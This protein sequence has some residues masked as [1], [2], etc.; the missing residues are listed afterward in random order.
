MPDG[1]ICLYDDERRVAAFAPVPIADVRGA[2]DAAQQ[3]T[4]DAAGAVLAASTAA[5]CAAVQ[6]GGAGGGVPAAGLSADGARRAPEVKRANVPLGW[7]APAFDVLQLEDYDW[8]IAGRS[9][10]AARRR[11]AMA[12]RLGYPARA[13]HYFAGFVLEPGGRGGAVAAD[14]GGGGRGRR[15][16]RDRA[17][18]FAWALPQVL[19]DGFVHFETRRR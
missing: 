12:E 13:Q 5:L 10:A 17:R 11:G 7:A 8:V 16:A 14:R 19:R 15:R 3:A 6:G 9:G 18:C 1:R 2:L 4:L